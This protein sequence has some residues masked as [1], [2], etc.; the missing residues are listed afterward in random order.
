MDASSAADADFWTIREVSQELG[1]TLRGAPGSTKGKRLI[2]PKRQNG[3]RFYRTT[4]V[5][6]LRTIVKLKSWGLSLREIRELL[7]SPGDGPYGLTEHLREELVERLIAQRAGAEAALADLRGLGQHL[8][9][10]DATAQDADASPEL[11][12]AQFSLAS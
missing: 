9:A 7:Q 12:A 3:L 8:E 2:A 4:D 1:L 6:R 11:S 10:G 5:E